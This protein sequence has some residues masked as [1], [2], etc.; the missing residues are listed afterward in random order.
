MKIALCGPSGSGKT[1]IANY[2]TELSREDNDLPEIN[3]MS[4]SATNVMSEETVA[5]L[6]HDFGDFDGHKDVIQKSMHNPLFAYEFQMS[7]LESRAS[8]VRDNDNFIIDRSPID[9]W[10]YFLNQAAIHSTRAARQAFLVTCQELYKDL[11]HVIFI[12]TIKDNEVEDNGSRVSNI[13][14]QR[15][16][17]AIFQQEG[18][19]H[20]F[21]KGDKSDVNKPFFLEIDF[22]NLE[23]RK[24]RVKRFLEL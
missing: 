22:W 7:L 1:T 13:H 17:N 21:D 11:T 24:A 3:F 5:R 6:K 12:H 18:H 19:D 20:F 23:E 16:V 14:Y 4:S 9:N 15:M 2:I 8:Q 10:V